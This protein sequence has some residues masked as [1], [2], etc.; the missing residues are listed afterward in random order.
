MEGDTGIPVMIISM[1]D[2]KSVNSSYETPPVAF[3]S[4][5]THHLT[6]QGAQHNWDRLDKKIHDWK[7]FE[8]NQISL[9]DTVNSIVGRYSSLFSP[10]VGL[11]K[12]FTE[13]VCLKSGSNPVFTKA[14]QLSFYKKTL[15][16][17]NSFPMG[18]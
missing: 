11:V 3:K 10:K 16:E 4:F 14:R 12:S 6:P 7:T 13:Q 18:R 5:T 17:K 8:L 15:I 2:F 9:D 1:R